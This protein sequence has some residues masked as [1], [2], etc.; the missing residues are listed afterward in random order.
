MFSKFVVFVAAIMAIT[1]SSGSA[2]S[3]A[4]AAGDMQANTA[5][6]AGDTEF[7]ACAE[8]CLQR[9]SQVDQEIVAMCLNNCPG[10]VRPDQVMVQVNYHVVDTRRG[11]DEDTYTACIQSCLQYQGATIDTCG[12]SCSNSFL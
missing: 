3:V 11:S 2:A 7:T 9:W 6:R 5:R 12:Q 1:V 8:S 10:G 4:S